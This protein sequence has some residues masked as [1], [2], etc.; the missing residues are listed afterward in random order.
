MAGVVTL[1]VL[2][3]V[4]KATTKKG[5]KEKVHPLPREKNPGYAYGHSTLFCSSCRLT[6]YVVI[7][8]IAVVIMQ[9]ILLSQSEK[10]LV[11]VMHETKTMNFVS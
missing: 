5:K 9:S 4:L 1:V 10:Q 7:T 8:H 3:C 11:I 2:A 6:V